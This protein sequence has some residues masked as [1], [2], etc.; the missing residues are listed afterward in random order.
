MGCFLLLICPLR[1][2]A[3]YG[4]IRGSHL[5]A[6]YG[7]QRKRQK[8]TLPGVSS[9]C[10]WL[11]SI[12]GLLLWHFIQRA[13]SSV[14][15]FSDLHRKDMNYPR[16]HLIFLMKFLIM[17]ISFQGAAFPKALKVQEFHSMNWLCLI[18]G[19]SIYSCTLF[20]KLIARVHN[21]LC[22]PSPLFLITLFVD[23]LSGC[24]VDIT[25]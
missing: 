21:P 8:V 2:A 22:G 19:Q 24:K 13:E 10:M 7:R 6:Y 20:M 3:L 5:A 1:S 11:I 25:D 14:I 17:N 23:S 9:F 4:L 16:A 12:L 15:S 18:L